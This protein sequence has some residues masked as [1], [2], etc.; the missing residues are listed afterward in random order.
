MQGLRSQG[1]ACDPSESTS[2]FVQILESAM[3]ARRRVF[4]KASWTRESWTREKTGGGMALAEFF[5]E[6]CR[7]HAA[8][9][10]LPQR[11]EVADPFDDRVCHMVL[12]SVSCRCFQMLACARRQGQDGCRPPVRCRRAGR[13]F[14]QRPFARAPCRARCQ[15]LWRTSSA[16]STD[17]RGWWQ[18][19]PEARACRGCR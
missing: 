19:S 11:A 1:Q 17:A 3:H 18:G 12:A 7:V 4:A 15:V 10:F 2:F 14:R 9:L 13:R 16:A 5:D 6:V 8:V